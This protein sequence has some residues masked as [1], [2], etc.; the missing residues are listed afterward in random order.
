[1]PVLCNCVANKYS[2][3]LR[4][5]SSRV[6]CVVLAVCRFPHTHTHTL[7]RTHPRYASVFAASPQRLATVLELGAL[8]EGSTY[9]FRLTAFA[10]GDDDSVPPVSAFAEVS[11]VVNSPPSTGSFLVSPTEGVA[12]TTS[13]SLSCEAWVDEDIPLR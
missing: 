5:R 9:A 2:Y 4:S 7:A 8:T 11:V 1:M 3:R 13:F 12:L 6:A 10:Q